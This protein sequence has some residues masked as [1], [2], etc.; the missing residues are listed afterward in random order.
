MV[1]FCI[2]SSSLVDGFANDQMTSLEKAGIVLC[3]D[4]GSFRNVQK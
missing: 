2:F 1:E 3:F 4:A